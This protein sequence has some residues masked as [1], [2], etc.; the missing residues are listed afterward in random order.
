MRADNTAIPSTLDFSS[1]GLTYLKRALA[2]PVHKIKGGLFY[3]PASFSDFQVLRQYKDTTNALWATTQYEQAALIPGHTTYTPCISVK[4]PNMPHERL[5]PI[6]ADI[7]FHLKQSGWKMDGQP[8]EFVNSGSASCVL[9]LGV[10]ATKEV[11]NAQPDGSLRVKGANFPFLVL[12]IASTQSNDSIETKIHHWV[13]GSRGH[14]RFIIVIKIDSKASTPRVLASV[15]QPRRQNTPTADNPHAYTMQAHRVI[16]NKEIYPTTSNTTFK[17]ARADVLPRDTNDFDTS[18]NPLTFSIY[19]FGTYA[20]QAVQDLE[21]GKEA[22]KTSPRDPNQAS[23]SSPGGSPGKSFVSNSSS[24]REDPKDPP[25]EYEG[26]KI[27]D[28]ELKHDRKSRSGR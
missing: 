14:L 23:L 25:Y 21:E 13:Q 1:Q 3:V 20:M 9:K 28:E 26:P 4:M 17:I 5:K 22:G 24:G 12:E 7:M 8:I 11:K 16:D 2:Y 15:I 19:S 10:K 6:T 18:A 27:T